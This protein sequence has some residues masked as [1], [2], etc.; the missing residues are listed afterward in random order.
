LA[1]QQA[2]HRIEL[3]QKDFLPDFGINLTY[4]DIAPS[5]LM[6]TA[7]GADAFMIGTEV[8]IPLWRD[9]LHANLEQARLQ[10]QRFEAV[11]EDLASQIRTRLHD[12]IRQLKQERDMLLL[13]RETLLP[14]ATLTVESTLA[15]YS[16]GQIG[17]QDMLEAERT[18]FNLELDFQKTQTQHLLTR[19]ELEYELGIDLAL[20]QP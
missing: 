8:R 3:A 18:R 15:A 10:R 1:Q 6:P 5:D 12:L 16:T 13:Y 11:E 9:K 19:A 7:T 14:Q 4:F 17:F 20:V 2:D